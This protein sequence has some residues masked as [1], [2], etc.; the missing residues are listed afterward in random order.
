MRS[1]V[2]PFAALALLA[3]TVALVQPGSRAPEVLAALV[4]TLGL[5]AAALLVPWRRLPPSAAVAVPL[6]YFVVIAVLRDADG[7]ATSRWTPLVLLPV[8]WL[9]LNGSRRELIAALAL[10]TVTLGGP[11][12]VAGAPAYP[13]DEWL[14]VAVWLA[15]GAIVGGS[16]QEL[17]GSVRRA[18]ARAER[19]LRKAQLADERFSRAL[20]LT[21]VGVATL[22]LDGR[23]LTANPAFCD[24][25]GRSEPELLG[26][27]FRSVTHPD[28]TR[29]GDRLAQE[30][31]SGDRA[32]F[33]IEKRYL[34]PDGSEA[35]GVLSC[36][37]VTEADGTPHEF[38]CHAQDVTERRAEER[39]AAQE[40]IDLIRVIEVAHQVAAEANARTAICEGTLRVASADFVVLFEPDGR[41]GLAATAWSGALDSAPAAP[42]GT[43]ASGARQAFNTRQRV[44]VAD[45]VGDER[46]SQRLVELT[47]AGSVLFE[48][49]VRGQKS[50]GV[51]V[52][53]WHEPTTDPSD[54]LAS[55][56][57]LLAAEAAVALQREDLL[58]LLEEAARTD[59][60][61]GI[62]NRRGWRE[63][64][65]REAARCKRD[66][67]PLTVAMVD[68]DH[69][70]AYNDRHGHQTGDRL[71]KEAA[72]A[73]QAQLRRS[74]LIARY[75]GEEFAVLM[76]NCPLEDSF[77]IIERLCAATPGS[78]T[79]SAGIA[80][81]RAES[82]TL[83]QLVNRADAALYAAKAA[84]RDQYSVAP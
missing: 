73:W 65:E 51:L 76:A 53:G 27:D 40:A 29:E 32:A 16:V 50:V 37:L 47:G 38:L 18:G 52:C 14:R 75:G 4:L 20:E 46:I 1:S 68:L 48:P 72:S 25:V 66:H 5:A 60:L 81:W 9:A 57:S 35:V 83:E 8:T 24:L 10:A 12:V 21:P 23:Y 31:L 34:R 79:V 41:D 63:T 74:D 44:F 82:E 78:Q 13:D 55:L 80:G 71:L 36:T 11:I 62:A 61:T 33:T 22:D 17:V 15:I 69:F 77:E 3:P 42:A 6:A 49:V 7:G 56:I 58:S 67:S 39:R 54:R 45:A 2:T 70:K 43:E 28:D 84:G 59:E 26:Q 19:H 64:L 30:L